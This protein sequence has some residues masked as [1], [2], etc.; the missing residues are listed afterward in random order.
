MKNNK[1]EID[2]C[3]GTLMDKLISFALPLMLSG[4]LQLM[5]N[6]LAVVIAATASCILSDDNLV[7]SLLP[8]FPS[9]VV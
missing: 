5:F 3:N 4:M 6:A 7:P 9:V 1:Y 2:M 8:L